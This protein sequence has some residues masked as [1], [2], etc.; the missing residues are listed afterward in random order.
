MR[1]ARFIICLLWA[2]YGPSA[3]ALEAC[4]QNKVSS[5]AF[6]EKISP[7]LLAGESIDS[8]AG[9]CFLLNIASSREQLFTRLIK[10]EFPH[11][12]FR[13]GSTISTSAR[14]CDF[15]LVKNQLVQVQDRSARVGRRSRVN[16]T[17]TVNKELSRMSMKVS[18]GKKH[19]L[20]LSKSSSLY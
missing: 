12:R 13:G 17:K 1:F 9:N 3:L 15:E 7:F 16:T 10:M 14:T 8:S 2:I 20:S 18:Q 5:S 19:L 11:A 6:N 4:F